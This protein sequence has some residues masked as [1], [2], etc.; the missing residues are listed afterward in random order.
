MLQ[1]EAK[2]E[3]TLKPIEGKNAETSYTNYFR[4]NRSIIDKLFVG[5]V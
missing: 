2:G 3:V 1:E 5:Q 4:N